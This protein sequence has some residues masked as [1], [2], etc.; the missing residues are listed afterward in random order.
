MKRIERKPEFECYGP[1]ASVDN[2]ADYSN[3]A[4]AGGP[5]HLYKSLADG[6]ERLSMS[7]SIIISIVLPLVLQS[8]AP[9][10]RENLVFARWKA[11]EI[12]STVWANHNRLA[13]PHAISPD[14]DP[15]SIGDS[16]TIT[17]CNP[18]VQLV[19]GN[20]LKIADV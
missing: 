13:V 16:C 9:D 8:V 6:A 10:R 11:A 7:F 14:G 17:Q 20:D 19:T 3:P 5:A 4:P 1:I 15:H 2:S 12:E 18:S